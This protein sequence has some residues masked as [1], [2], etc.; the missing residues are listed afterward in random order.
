M[1]IGLAQRNHIVSSEHNAS[2]LSLFC[3]VYLLIVLVLLHSNMLIAYAAY[4]VRSAIDRN[5]IGIF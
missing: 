2:L 5:I 4:E 3:V 1:F